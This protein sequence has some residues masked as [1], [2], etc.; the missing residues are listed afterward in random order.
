[1]GQ[2]LVLAG[3]KILVPPYEGG[4]RAQLGWGPSTDKTEPQRLKSAKIREGT[5][6][7]GRKG[8]ENYV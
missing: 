2:K 7:H 5:K 8:K 1:L 6:K 4:E 3:K